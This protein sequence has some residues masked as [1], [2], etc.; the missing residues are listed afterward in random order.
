M[1]IY[2]LK[3]LISP[4]EQWGECDHGVR[5]VEV[6]SGAQDGGGGS[7]TVCRTKKVFGTPVNR[8]PTVSGQVTGHCGK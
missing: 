7:G 8:K 6:I 1:L 2:I 4:C 3:A 5:S